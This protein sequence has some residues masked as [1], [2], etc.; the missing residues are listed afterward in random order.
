MLILVSKIT[1]ISNEFAKYCMKKRSSIIIECL[2]FFFTVLDKSRG[3]F[4]LK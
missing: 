3:L 4:P 2:R 1:I